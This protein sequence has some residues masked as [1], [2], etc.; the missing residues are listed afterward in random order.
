M[1][2]KPHKFTWAVSMLATARYW[3]YVYTSK[4]NML[5]IPLRPTV[6]EEPIPILLH[7]SLPKQDSCFPTSCC[8][9][10]LTDYHTASRNCVGKG[11]M[12]RSS[13]T[14]GSHV[15]DISSSLIVWI[16]KFQFQ[17]TFTAYFSSIGSMVHLSANMNKCVEANRITHNNEITMLLH[18]IIYVKRQ[19]D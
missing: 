13:I 4:L 10:S 8:N 6:M 14:R 17:R 15:S 3:G 12:P 9:W 16:L 1:Y 11:C 5:M 7:S 19:R 18:S 2:C